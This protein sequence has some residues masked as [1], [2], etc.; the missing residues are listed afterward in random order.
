MLQETLR[1]KSWMRGSWGVPKM[2]PG[3]PC[4][5]MRPPSMRIT[6]CANSRANYI[7]SHDQHGLT[8]FGDAAHQIW[9][10]AHPFRIE[11]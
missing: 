6:R 4:S 9:H 8:A 5:T 3:G 2:A 10:F 11:R 1:K 7:M